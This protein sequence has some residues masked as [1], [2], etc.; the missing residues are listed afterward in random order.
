MSEK[1]YCGGGTTA[2]ESEK[3][4]VWFISSVRVDVGLIKDEE[5]EEMIPVMKPFF[6]FTKIQKNKKAC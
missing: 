2:K 1:S 4:Q 3:N 6:G 5:E